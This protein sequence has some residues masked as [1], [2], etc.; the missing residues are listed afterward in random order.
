MSEQEANNQQIVIRLM[1][2]IKEL[3]K[4]L[5]DLQECIDYSNEP[6]AGEGRLKMSPMA[7]MFEKSI[8]EELKKI[9]EP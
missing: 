2:R 3:E 9:Q 4:Y 5:K 7:G 6:D 8:L 1:E